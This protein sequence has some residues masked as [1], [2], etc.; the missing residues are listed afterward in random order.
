MSGGGGGHCIVRSK[1][2]KFGHACEGGAE[3]GPCTEGW[4]RGS[5]DRAGALYVGVWDRQTRLKTLPSR[6]FVG[7]R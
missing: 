4:G 7:G 3:P 1:V 6:H 2:T 5:S